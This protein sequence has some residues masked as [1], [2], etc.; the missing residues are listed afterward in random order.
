VRHFEINRIRDSVTSLET[1]YETSLKQSQTAENLVNIKL[2]QSER[3]IRDQIENNIKQRFTSLDLRRQKLIDQSQHLRQRVEQMKIETENWKSNVTNLAIAR[4]DLTLD[5]SNQ[6]RERVVK[7]STDMK[8]LE[9]DMKLFVSQM[10]KLQ[11]LSKNF[12]RD[13]QKLR[14][15]VQDASQV[16]KTNP[17]I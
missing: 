4:S 15:S 8:K 14:F 3:T 2:D 5:S 16:D 1:A 12:D 13:I 6:L 7:M 9:N 17:R 11:D 10:Y